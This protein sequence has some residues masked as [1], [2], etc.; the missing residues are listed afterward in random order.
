MAYTLKLEKFEGPFDLILDLIEEKKLSI[1]ELSLAEICEDYLKYL[2]SCE[3]LPREETASFLVAAA[4]L[5]LIK[6]KSL[7]P[8]IETQEEDEESI[9]ELKARLERLKF[10][11]K[12]GGVLKS[13]MNKKNFIFFKE[14][15]IE[16]KLG[17]YPGKDLNKERLHRAMKELLN[18]LPKKEKLPEKILNR[19][20]SIEK[21]IEE[22]I[23]RIQKVI[24]C[25]FEEMSDSTD[26]IDKILSFLA[27]LELLKQGLIKVKQ[28]KTFGNIELSKI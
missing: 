12:L 2:R 28:E 20:Y 24:K 14:A 10:F 6:S 9:E 26:K 7:F 3:D 19:V 16:Q 13:E 8:F 25:S 4:A 15:N 21:K 22:L 23:S 5:M 27:V 18:V 17:F 11:R 1:S